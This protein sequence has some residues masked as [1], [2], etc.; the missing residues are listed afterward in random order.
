MHLCNT[1]SMPKALV[2]L[3]L[4]VVAYLVMS[5]L[6]VAKAD[7]YLYENEATAAAANNSNLRTDAYR[8]FVSYIEYHWG[9]GACSLGDYPCINY[10]DPWMT[11]ANMYR[12][13]N[14]DVRFDSQWFVYPVG[15]PFS[16]EL[17][18]I[19][20]VKVVENDNGSKSVYN[21]YTVQEVV[22]F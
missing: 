10:D 3:M 14:R 1:W 18:I 22:N 17:R 12:A 7:A 5:T 13:G 8:K 21:L 4:V 16:D 19:F 6:I 20:R 15:R 9:G 11:S 2:A